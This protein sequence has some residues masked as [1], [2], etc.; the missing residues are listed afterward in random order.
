MALTAAEEVHSEAEVFQATRQEAAVLA[1]A[2][3][4]HYSQDRDSP[5]PAEVESAAASATMAA[6]ITVAEASLFRFVLPIFFL[7]VPPLWAMVGSI[8]TL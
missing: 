4:E 7:E 6:I 2:A 5:R 1:E 3:E 8:R